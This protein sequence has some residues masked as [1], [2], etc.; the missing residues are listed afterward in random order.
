[1]ITDISCDINGPIAS[2]I[3]ETSINEPFYDY[4]PQSDII[5]PAF[6][7]NKNILVSTV[8]NLPSILPYDSTNY[9]SKILTE[10]VFPLLIAKKENEIIKNATIIQQGR[11]TFAFSY[12]NKYI[13]T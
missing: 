10:K 3:K 8:P 6:S 5:E 1:V 9:F 7:S 2:S 13:S 11:L 12:L 4:N